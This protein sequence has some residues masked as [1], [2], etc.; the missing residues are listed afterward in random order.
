[1]FRHLTLSVLI[2]VALVVAGHIFAWGLTELVPAH[3]EATNPAGVNPA[4]SP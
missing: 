4:R 3:S 2:A 1:M